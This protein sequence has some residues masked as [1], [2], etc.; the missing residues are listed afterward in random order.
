VDRAVLEALHQMALGNVEPDLTLLLDLPAE[1]GLSRTRTRESVVATEET[2]F[3][4]MS[5]GFHQA[6]RA[7]FIDLAAENPQRVAI[8]D[9]TQ[10]VATVAA[11]VFDT[12]R[13]RLAWDEMA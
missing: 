13:T 1:L 11:N 7:G 3:E 5:L 6:L 8:I 10:G 2:R 4:R 9:A 12:V